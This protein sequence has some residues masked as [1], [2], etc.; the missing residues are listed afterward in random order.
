MEHF[1]TLIDGVTPYQDTPY[2]SREAASNDLPANPIGWTIEI[3]PCHD[4]ACVPVYIQESY[5][6]AT[7]G[8]RFGDSD[9]YESCY[10]FAEIGKLFRF[11]QREYGACKSAVYVDTPGDKATRIGWV[12]G[13]RERYE[14]TGEPYTREVWVTLHTAPDTVTRQAHYATLG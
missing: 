11:C 13:R 8:Y 6:N 2:P 5:V 10:S 14:D 1:H 3:E 4:K 9:V 12:F 7:K